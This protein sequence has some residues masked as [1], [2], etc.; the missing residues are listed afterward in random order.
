MATLTIPA[1]TD[2]RTTHLA[3]IDQIVFATSGTR[4]AAAKFGGAQFGPQISHGVRITGD[5]NANSMHVFVDGVFSAAGWSFAG[6]DADDAVI[7][8]GAA[9]ADT[10]TGST[11][12]D[13]VGGGDGADTITGGAGADQL[14][15]GAGND[16]F[17]F[18]NTEDAAAGE[19]IDGGAGID[20]IRLEAAGVADFRPVAIAGLETLEF[21]A[22]TGSQTA[23]LSAAQLT[24]F[25][26]IVGNAAANRIVVEDASSIDLSGH[27][28]IGWD[29]GSDEIAINGSDRNDALTGSAQDDAIAGGA[30]GD[31]LAG[32]GGDDTFVYGAAAEL[33][34]GETID[35]GPGTD[36]IR[37]GGTGYY[38]FGDRTA[39]YAPVS[40]IEQVA[41][42][43]AP[44]TSLDAWFRADQLAGL[45]T[46]AG[47]SGINT[48]HLQA[49]T[50][51]D[52]SG[53]VL[54]AWRLEDSINV[55]GSDGADT[56]T[57]SSGRNHIFGGAGNDVLDGGDGTDAV[58]GGTG[59][60][61]FV[62]GGG[63][64]GALDL[65]G[66][67]IDGGLGTDTLAVTGWTDFRTADLAGIEA[68]SF[69][70]GALNRLAFTAAQFASITSVA[71]STAADTIHI[72]EAHS[73]DVS[74]VQFGWSVLDHMR[75]E[76]TALDDDIRLSGSLSS[77]DVFGGDG[78]DIVHGGGGHD[79]IRGQA[80]D[81]LLHGEDGNDT[82]VGGPGADTM[83]GGVGAD[84]FVWATLT[85]TGPDGDT[86]DIVTDARA[87][88]GDRIDLQAIDANEELAGDQ[89][90]T[91]IGGELFSAAG[92]I[93]VFMDDFN[94]FLAFSTD[95]DPDVEGLIRLNG[96]G[97]PE[98]AWFVL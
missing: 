28:F 81:D 76:G 24:G 9:S 30:G 11:R 47:S 93:N 6:W 53:V 63:G 67:L 51:L 32:D 43:N 10:I 98:D 46:L 82:L 2:Y 17:V 34:A 7:L 69:A 59:D 26:R 87:Y 56:L 95:S 31:R 18:G 61:T 1:S 62:Y 12:R 16:V 68:I 90:F 75:V 39:A 78:S 38:Y 79:T 21:A 84:R 49:A 72:D 86:C 37:L 42:A 27:A 4:P 85:E 33:A 36:T 45:T 40:G 80:G 92:Q 58:A 97:T 73:L 77:D 64:N 71:G 5:A 8:E 88:Q 52:L 65:R 54:D 91:L 55:T 48:L 94:T 22:A 96:R 25:G 89:A 15:G 29:A 3:D 20:T 70:P 23:E 19:S 66:E 44:D 50:A 35:G 41:F 83:H 74:M 57:G 13:L 14:D 60:D